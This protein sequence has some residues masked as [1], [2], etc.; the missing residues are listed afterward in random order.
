MTPD[1]IMQMFGEPLT[2]IASARDLMREWAERLAVDVGQLEG[3]VEPIV[4]VA[5]ELNRV[6][7][8]MDAAIER[9]QGHPRTEGFING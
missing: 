7:E 5:R 6:A 3:D 2:V 9:N 8:R 1:Q 4:E